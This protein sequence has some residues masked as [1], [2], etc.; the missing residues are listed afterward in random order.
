MRIH[1]G[2]IHVC[3]VLE[4]TRGSLELE[5]EDNVS[6]TWILGIKFGSP[7]NHWAISLAP[8]SSS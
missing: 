7:P 5:L 8:H 6:L 3:G 1:V 2:A 4:E